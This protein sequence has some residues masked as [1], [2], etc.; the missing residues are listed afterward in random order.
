MRPNHIL[1]AVLLLAVPIALDG[2]VAGASVDAYSPYPTPPAP[3]AE[4]I[5]K[6]PVSEEAQIW[7]PGHW[8]WTGGGYAWT[9]G[10]W[11]TQTGHG[12]NWQEGHW[13]NRTGAWVWEPAHWLNG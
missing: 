9:S 7:Q 11:V 8:D 13:S 1:L 6:P 5:P 2:C 3:Q 10:L 12:R 4:V